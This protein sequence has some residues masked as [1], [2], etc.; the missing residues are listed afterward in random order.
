MRVKPRCGV[1]EPLQKIVFT[2]HPIATRET[3]R[4]KSVLGWKHPIWQVEFIKQFGV[5][6]SNPL[7][8]QREACFP[9][10][11]IP[12]NDRAGAVDVQRINK[13]L[14]LVFS[15]SELGREIHRCTRSKGVQNQISKI[16]FAWH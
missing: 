5:P 1:Y 7:D 15:A 13:T 4:G 10:T 2:H 6:Q 11:P 14:N 8:L 3:K 12:I 9:E 16:R